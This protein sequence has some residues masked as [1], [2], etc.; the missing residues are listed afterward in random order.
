LTSNREIESTQWVQTPFAPG[1]IDLVTLSPEFEFQEFMKETTMISFNASSGFA[2]LC[3]ALLVAACATEPSPADQPVAAATAAAAS[4]PA[5]NTSGIIPGS[6]ED[7][8]INVGDRILFDYDEFD[9]DEED[10]TILARQA[11]WLARYPAVRITI[12]GHA[13]ERGTREYNLALAARRVT[14]ARDYLASLGINT[15]RLETMSFGKERPECSDSSET[16]WSRNRR[17]V[18]KIGGAAAS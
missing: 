15:S 11:A 6:P 4:T 9:L 12:E 7:F 1:S 8:Q 17:S 5:P 3:S 14:A 18:A 2:C 13:D 10:Q 16:C